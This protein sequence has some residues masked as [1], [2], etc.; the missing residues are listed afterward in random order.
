MTH[1]G[2]E[3]VSAFLAEAGLLTGRIEE[4]RAAM[5]AASLTA[6]PPEGIATETTEL[7]GRAAEWLVPDGVERDA[8]ILYL[9]GGGYGSGS[10]NSH[11]D[12][13]A[14]IGIASGCA[15]VTLDYRLAPEDPFP[16]AVTDATAAYRQLVTE[17]MAPDRMVVAGDSA[18]GGLVVALLLALRAGGTPLPAAGVC[19][20]PWV[21]LTQSGASYGE[22]VDR[23]PMLSKEALDVLAAA[24]LAGTDARTELASPLFAENLSGL[25]PLLIEVG[26]H[27]VLL[28]DATRLAERVTAAGG[29]ATLT[30]WPE[31]IHVFQAFPGAILPETDLSVAAIG[32]FVSGHLAG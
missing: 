32:K 20:S 12:L 8:V 2:V 25:P 9:H 21:D 24:Y 1:P 6:P 27:E 17:G 16:A 23:D 13:A 14:R 22:L 19:L 26:A 5:D 7:G 15:V 3:M 4:Q 31:M 18:G 30:V 29:D 10:L 28:D 11:R